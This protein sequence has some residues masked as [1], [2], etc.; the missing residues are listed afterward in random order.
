M[1][2][3]VA[4]SLMAILLTACSSGGGGGSQDSALPV[5]P[6]DEMVSGLQLPAP[7]NTQT[8]NTQA[9]GTPTPAQ[10]STTST[11]PPSTE[12]I[13]P[14]SYG[15]WANFNQ[16]YY[17]VEETMW[18]ENSS[19]W[20]VHGTSTGSVDNLPQGSDGIKFE[21]TGPVWGRIYEGTLD[22]N[23][24]W[25]AND[26]DQVYGSLRAVYW[27]R[28]RYPRRDDYLNISLES[29]YKVLPGGGIVGTRWMSFEGDVGTDKYAEGYDPALDVA[30]FRLPANQYETSHGREQGEAVGSFYGSNGEAIAGTFWYRRGGNRIEG[31]F[32]GKR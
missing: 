11:P 4:V 30:T 25:E 9:P 31:A 17:R 3:H 27:T 7:S 12:S 6:G 8:T 18:D 14:T 24:V 21:Y 23:G 13:S 16:G 29:M 28:D 19:H 32:G 20:V 22:H 1:R 26:G 15:R 10:Q 5:M 2:D